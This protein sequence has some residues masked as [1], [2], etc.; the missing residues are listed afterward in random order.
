MS[1]G[2]VKPAAVLDD[3]SFSTFRNR[4]KNARHARAPG[5]GVMVRRGERVMKSN[6]LKRIEIGLQR[7]RLDR[8]FAMQTRAFAPLTVRELVLLAYYAGR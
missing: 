5:K 6:V 8:D 3:L 7:L 4:Q 1:Y 2:P